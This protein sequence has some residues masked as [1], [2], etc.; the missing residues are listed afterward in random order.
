MSDLDEISRSRRVAL[1]L[2]AVKVVDS[3]A[4]ESGLARLSH[5]AILHARQIRRAEP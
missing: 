3:A 4:N 5:G 2:L 1:R